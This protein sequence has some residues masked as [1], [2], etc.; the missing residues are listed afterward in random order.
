MGLDQHSIIG[1]YKIIRML[2]EGGMGAATLNL[3]LSMGFSQVFHRTALWYFVLSVGKW[4]FFS[5][6]I[7]RCFRIPGWKLDPLITT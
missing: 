1:H 3:L 2:G 5:P 4:I 7:R 6:E